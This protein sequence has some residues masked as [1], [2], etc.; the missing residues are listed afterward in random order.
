MAISTT[1]ITRPRTEI[2]TFSEPTFTDLDSAYAAYESAKA[3]DDTKT[4][5][6]RAVI[7]FYDGSSYCLIA[8]ASY[9]ERNSDPLG[10]VPEPSV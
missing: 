7:A 9:P 2:K 5:T 4:W 8:E 3:A 1:S 6:V 10:Q